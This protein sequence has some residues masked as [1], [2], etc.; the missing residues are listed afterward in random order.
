MQTR[1]PQRIR[2]PGPEARPARPEEHPPALRCSRFNRSW[3]ERT[4]RE[5]RARA[6]GHCSTRAVRPLAHCLLTLEQLFVYCNRTSVLIGVTRMSVTPHDR[7]DFEQ[8]ADSIE[9]V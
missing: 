8:E 5:G 3:P 9:R 6:L 4:C 7:A 1:P 2:W